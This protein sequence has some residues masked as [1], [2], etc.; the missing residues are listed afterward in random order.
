MHHLRLAHD[1]NLLARGEPWTP[2]SG[3]SLRSSCHCSP[4]TEPLSLTPSIHLVILMT[5]IDP[6]ASRPPCLMNLSRGGLCLAPSIEIHPVH[7]PLCPLHVYHERRS[8]GARSSLQIRV[9]NQDLEALDRLAEAHNL[10][11]SETV[12]R[13]LRGRSMPKTKIDADTYLELRRIGNNINQIAHACN[14]GFDPAKVEILYHLD[15]LSVVLEDVTRS[16]CL[17]TPA[18]EAS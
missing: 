5:P 4:H 1:P 9:D 2:R 14:G 7:G 16:L 17:G 15:R 18:Q 6:T 13:L 12:R 3:S 10:T 8:L 11:R